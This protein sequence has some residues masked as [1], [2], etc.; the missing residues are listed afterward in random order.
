MST[1]NVTDIRELTEDELNHVSG[2]KGDGGP[3]VYMEFKLK[4]V[5]VSAV[6]TSPPT[7][8]T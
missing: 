8:P 7:N 5:F 1:T 2:G 3:K 4:E 6:V